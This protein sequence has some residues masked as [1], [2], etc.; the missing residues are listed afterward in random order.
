MKKTKIEA[1]LTKGS[2]LDA[3][4]EL[5]N[6]KGYSQTSVEDIVKHLGLTRGAFYWHF[7]DKEDLVK[8][9][10][11]REHTY[12]A[13]I[14]AEAA[15]GKYGCRQ[16][17]IN[18]AT[19]SIDSFYENKRYRD[20]VYLVRFKMEFVSSSTYFEGLTNLNQFV[21]AEIVK[22]INE[23]KEKNEIENNIDP[24]STAVH[25]VSLNDG[26]FRM[27]FA[28]PDHLSNKESAKKIL[29]DYLDTI[30]KK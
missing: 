30:F 26:M 22:A 19:T 20:Y 5:F 2:I 23:R 9:L 12:I 13:G 25:L 21:V 24:E 6:E 29:N 28:L 10:I 8:K 18:L 4:M 3:S 27:Y 1:E 7:K 11:F 16:K 15:S 17:L 14:I